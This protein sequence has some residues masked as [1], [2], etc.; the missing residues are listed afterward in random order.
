[1]FCAL[2]TRLH[3]RP[4]GHASLFAARLL[5]VALLLEATIWTASAEPASYRAG[6]VRLTVAGSAEPFPAIVWYPTNVA[7]VPWQAGPFTIAATLNAPIAE[8]LRFPVVL[9]SHGRRGAPM[10]HRGLATGLARKGFIVVAPTHIGDAAGHPQAPSQAQVLTD[11]PRQAIAALDAALADSRFADRA[12]P[13][14]IGMIGYS[15]GGYTA[16]ILAG[17]KPDFAAALAYC[18]GEGQKDIGSCGPAGNGDANAS[19]ELEAWQPPS[20][21][22]LK[23]LVLMDPLAVMFGASGLGTVR[24]PALLLRPESDAYLSATRNARA[25]AAGLATPPQESVV[26]G[27]HFIFI[28]PCPEKIAAE[29]PLLCKDDPGIDRKAAHGKMEDEI[30]AFVL[31]HL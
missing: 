1:M 2:W 26:P 15:A 7:E 5:I 25:V 13:G 14:R 6:I 12:D 20:E 28:D 3:R 24:I 4:L 21:P 10:G 19:T 22:R 9:L 23:A 31:K 16:L 30:A 8:G 29:I 27:R 18:R 11:R 17:A